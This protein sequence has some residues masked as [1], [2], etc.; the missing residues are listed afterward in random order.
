MALFAQYAMA[1]AEE[2]LNDAG[3]SPESPE[4]LEATVSTYTRA[5]HQLLT[6]PG[7]VHRIR[8]RQSGRCGR[9]HSG[10]RKRGTRYHLCEEKYLELIH[11]G[12]PQSIAT[13][14]ASLAHQPRRRS[15]LHAVWLQRP[16]PCGY[17][18]MYHWGSRH[19]GCSTYG[20]FWRCRCYGIWRSR[21]MHPSTCYCWIRSCQKFG[22]GLE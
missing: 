21:I 5:M 3:W 7:G 9:Y 20:G 16:Q 18:G 8:N 4:D 12:L 22:Y 11:V 1:S 6:R 19:R 13:I 10:I 14:R 15:H 2:A 17:Y